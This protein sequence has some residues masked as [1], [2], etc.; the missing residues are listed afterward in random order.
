MKTSGFIFTLLLLLSV[1]KTVTAQRIEIPFNA[2]W[3]FTGGSVTGEQ[4]SM[5]VDVP[6]TWNATDAQEGI[7]YYRGEGTYVKSFIPGENWKN[8][9]VF[10]RFGGVMTTAK[11]YLNDELL[12]EHKG[13]YSAF[14]FELTGKLKPGIEN[15]V[16]VIANNEYTLEVLPLFGDFNVYGGI[17]RPVNLLVTPQICISPL[18]FASPGIYLKQTEI[19][20]NIANVQ[21]EVKI[22]NNTGETKNTTI[23]TT[24][25]D[26]GGN[27]MQ[28]VAED[29]S[30]ANGESTYSKQLTLSKPRLWNG[31]TDAYLYH[32]K[33]DLLQNGEI[34]DSKTEP[35][36]LRTVKVDP[37]EGFFL[38]GK[39]MP[40][41]GVSRHQDRQDKGNAL[42]YNDHREDMDL[43]LEMGI[44]A[45]RLAHYQHAEPVYDMA[46]SAGIVV[47]AELPW[48]GGPGSLAGGSNGYE[49]TDAFHTNAKQQLKELIRQNFNHPSI[50]FWSI[51]NEIQNPEDPS[52][53]P[54]INELN[55]LAK[56]EDQSRITVGASML[57][58]NEGIH[59]I[60]EAIAWNRYFGWYY[61]QPEDMGDF[62][63]ETHKTWPGLC[64]G[65]SEYGAG[66][67]INQHSEKTEKPNP[68][69][70]PH[71]EEW[72]N[73]YHEQHLKIYNARKYVWGTFLWNMF[74]FGS[75]FRREGDHYGINDKGLVTFDRKIKKDAFY[76]FKAN[77]SGEPV[78]HLTSKK[79]IFREKDKIS[80]KVYSNLPSVN[81]MVNGENLGQQTPVDGICEWKNVILKKGNNAIGVKGEL[82]GKIFTDN[83]VWV[84][85]G[86]GT[87]QIAKIFDLLNYIPH[88]TIIGLI[89]LVWLWF[90]GWRK[91]EQTVKWKRITARVFFIIVAL[92]V[93]LMLAL[94]IAV[95]TMMG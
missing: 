60:T 14:I 76:F 7:N 28:N 26:A 15:T 61:A 72:Q 13:G 71:P 65:I 16:K 90:K 22:S 18:D 94:K 83:C 57:D 80:V 49:P 37:N 39:H 3:N 85:D 64:I 50:C 58:P 33:I 4:I 34:T 45:L 66:A 74:D 43:M 79:F 41:H 9:R 88:F 48:V 10:I 78:L 11:V 77:W 82:N 19:N 5:N 63:D 1:I 35:L 92:V 38:N 8:K 36:G 51:F 67:S 73:Y 30:A 29:F 21:V 75:Y 55:K 47:W 87:K 56:T 31:K 6:H 53:V 81:L 95:S 84:R 46:D 23:Q 44:N 25:F 32:V 17:Y 70:S 2:N 86:F 40:L 91:K 93:V 27:A 54:F 62:L 89:V 12:G 59:D 20:E 69:G 42:S 52:P 24:V 68:F